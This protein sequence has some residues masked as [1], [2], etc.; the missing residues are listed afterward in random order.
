MNGLSASADLGIG[1]SFAPPW[2]SAAVAP[3]A[4]AGVF[5]PQPGGNGNGVDTGSIL[6]ALNPLRPFGLTIV[7]GAVAVALLL[8]LRHTLPA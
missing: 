3:T 2:A 5:G 1:T 7:S 8:F 6:G 4:S